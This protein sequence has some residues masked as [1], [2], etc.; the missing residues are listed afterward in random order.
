VFRPPQRQ[1]AVRRGSALL[2]VALLSLAGRAHAHPA[3]VSSIDRYLGVDRLRDGSVR[4]VYRL[5]FA[6]LPA[7]VQLERLDAD[8]DGRGTP[9]ERD[10]YL[11]ALLPPLIA[12]WQIDLDGQRV[13][14]RVIKRALEAPAGQG[15][16]S[17]LNVLVSLQ[18]DRAF[19]PARDV[20]VR[21][22]DPSYADKPGVREMGASDSASCLVV[23]AS[24]P[25][26][27]KALRSAAQPPRIDDASFTLRVRDAASGAAA[28]SV[29]AQRAERAP[30]PGI[31]HFA[32]SLREAHSGSAFWLGALAL[33]F[34]LGAGRALS[35]VHG[36]LRVAGYLAAGKASWRDAIELAASVA[37]T[38][39][40]G[41]FVLGLSA[42]L[43]ETRFASAKLFRVLELNSGALIVALALWQLP[44][45]ARLALGLAQHPD[46][47]EQP[48]GHELRAAGDR[49]G[50]LLLGISSQLLPCPSALVVLLLAVATHRIALG[51]ALVG[52]FSLGLSC[53]LSALGIALL[54]T[55]AAPWRWPQGLLLPRVAPLVSGLCVLALGLAIV[56]AAWAG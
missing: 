31:Q 36:K 52:A 54:R 2:C 23:A 53:V 10:A 46:A 1:R 30:P 38:Q 28:T 4:L 42:L 19:D 6:E 7:Y 35:P 14:P 33:A 44:A 40:A 50:A 49:R 22:R 34:A 8:H 26:L 41:I 16:L 29:S 25:K 37:L 18:I 9:R 24:V 27:D 17:T 43:L 51:L 5:D 32:A 12:A 11:D 15:G 56:L 45:R 47:C 48:H 21:M 55:R 13:A 39:T 20:V 3:G